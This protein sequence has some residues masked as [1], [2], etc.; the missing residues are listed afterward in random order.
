MISYEARRL[1]AEANQ[2]D[3]LADSLYRAAASTT[4]PAT[5]EDLLARSRR[6]GNLAAALRQRARDIEVDRPRLTFGDVD[7]PRQ[8]R[9]RD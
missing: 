3:A 1:E 5:K 2:Q 7:M 4:D 8:E 9:C 6:A